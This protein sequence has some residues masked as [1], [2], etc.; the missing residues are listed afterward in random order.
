MSD[1]INIENSIEISKS[2]VIEVFSDSEKLKPY[3]EQVAS[4]VHSDSVDLSTKTSR[5]EIASRA[6]K[7]SKIKSA[8]TK[9][10]KDSVSD[11]RNKVNAVNS[12]VKYVEETLSDL[13]DKTRLPLTEWEQ[14]QERIEQERL[15]N[16]KEKVEGIR[17]I[18]S[19]SGDESIE[20]ISALIEAVNAIDITVG[21][22]EFSGEAAK[23]IA[24]AK[25]KLSVALSE[26]ANKAEQ[27]RRQRELEEKRACDSC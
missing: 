25:S 1:L 3:L 21:F 22:D 6:H 12:G 24:E 15:S 5:K 23:A 11:L 9:I 8:L 13:R 14:E 17:A 26:T 4:Q 18:A 27:D 7:V 20:A 2:E 19:L 10:G 16:I